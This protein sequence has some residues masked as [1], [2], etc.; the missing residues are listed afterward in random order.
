MGLAAFNR[1][2]LKQA[3]AAKQEKPVEAK[4]DK[5]PQATAKKKKAAK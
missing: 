4:E 3:E 5:E 2:R 1:N